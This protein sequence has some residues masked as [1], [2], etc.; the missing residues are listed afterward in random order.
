MGFDVFAVMDTAH[1]TPLAW[2]F[3][4]LE[5][6]T[7]AAALK[8][9]LSCGGVINSLYCLAGIALFVTGEAP[10][11]VPDTN[12]LGDKFSMAWAGWKFSGCFYYALVN[13]GLHGGLAMGLAMVPYVVFDI[14]AL[15]DPAHW[16]PLSASFILLDGAMGVLGLMSYFKQPKAKGA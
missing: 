5:A 9:Y 16:T 14:F 10:V 11:G 13:L 7:G 8:G 15:Q 4:F 6:L 2:S 12:F 1:W 3:I